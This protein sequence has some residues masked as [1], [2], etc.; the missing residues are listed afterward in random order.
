MIR[1]V[2]KEDITA[3]AAI[4]NGYIADTCI[5]FETERLSAD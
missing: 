4:Y 3:I 1:N 5:T 2:R